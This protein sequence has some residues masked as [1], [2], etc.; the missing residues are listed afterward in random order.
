MPAITALFHHVKGHQKETADHKLTLLEKLTIDCDSRTATLQPTL[1][2]A[3]HCTH[4]LN[5]A[6]H[7]HLVIQG[8][9]ITQRLQHTL[10]DAATKHTYF[11][12]LTEKFHWTE[13]PEQAIHWPILRLTLKHFKATERCTLQKFIHEWLAISSMIC[14]HMAYTTDV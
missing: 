11:E 12:Y 13:N 10:R 14:M 6:G 4:P 7:P 2:T 1:S 9:V 8:N 3:P 5:S